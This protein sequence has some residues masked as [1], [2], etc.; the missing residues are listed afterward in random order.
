MS[1]GS[2]A[3]HQAGTTCLIAL[4]VTR[5]PPS[6][7]MQAARCQPP[8]SRLLCCTQSM[9]SIVHPPYSLS[10]GNISASHSP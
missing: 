10:T 2:T 9:G 3:H 5:R 8:M 1:G 7:H 6:P 4:A